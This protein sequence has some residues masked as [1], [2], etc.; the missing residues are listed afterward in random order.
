MISLTITRRA[1]RTFTLAPSSRFCNQKNKH[2]VVLDEEQI[3]AKMREMK[4]REG[5]EDD[6]EKKPRR[7]E[8]MQNYKIVK[9]RPKVLKFREET[10]TEHIMNF[11]DVSL[12]EKPTYLCP[13]VGSFKS[14]PSAGRKWKWTASATLPR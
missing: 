12:D 13:H 14:P 11:E 7:V 8:L 3:R 4:E 1:L 10:K 2:G 9:E 5:K 6:K